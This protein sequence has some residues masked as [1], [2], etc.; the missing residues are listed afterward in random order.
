MAENKDTAKIR[1]LVD[2]SNGDKYDFKK[3]EVYELSKSLCHRWVRRNVASY[4]DIG[5]VEEA[6]KQD[7]A[8]I[9]GGCDGLV[10]EPRS[11]PVPDIIP[12]DEPEPKKV[13]AV[14]RAKK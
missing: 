10:L 13:K 5:I 4:V 1:F 3:G 14:K 11:S 2:R 8:P 12:L 7:A 9:Y 6:P